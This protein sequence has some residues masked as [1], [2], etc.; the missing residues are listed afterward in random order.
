[1]ELIAIIFFLGIYLLISVGVVK[2]AMAWA[3]RHQRRVWLW[4]GLAGF[5]MYNLVFWDWIPTMV[6]HKYY[7][8]TQAGFTVFK[9]PEQWKHENP[10]LSNESLRPLIEKQKISMPFKS[11]PS[12]PTRKVQMLNPRIYHGLESEAPVLSILPLHKDIYY[13]SD[14]LNDQRLAQ[15]VSFSIYYHPNDFGNIKFWMKGNF[16]GHQSM[17]DEM[18]ETGYTKYFNEILVMEY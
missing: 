7:C 8:D 16:C 11:L 18:Q 9:T 13:F 3:R 4:G 1:M 14:I 6:A 12:D 17:A 10:N 5:I 2:A 15:L